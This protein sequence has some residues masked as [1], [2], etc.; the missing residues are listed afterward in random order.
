MTFHELV[1]PSDD[2]DAD[3]QTLAAFDFD[4]TLTYRHTFWRYL[5][6]LVGRRRFYGALIKLFMR[7]AVGTSTRIPGWMEGRDL[8]FSELLTGLDARWEQHCAQHFAQH[9][10]LS[11]LRPAALE[12]LRWHQ[13][14]GHVLVIVSNSA[15]SYLRHVATALGCHAAFGTRLEVSEGRLTGRRN[16]PSCVRAEKVARLRQHF[17]EL[18]RF[19][20]VEYGDSEGDRELLELAHESHYRP[21]RRKNE[22]GARP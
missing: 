21:F 19:H 9:Y 20:L 18:S 16:G 5:R 17:G 7:A 12:R 13:R 15:E 6:L 1:P 3:P 8:L 4:G 14:Q 10:A 22:R 11:W 2:A